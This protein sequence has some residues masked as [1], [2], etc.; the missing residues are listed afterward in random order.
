MTKRKICLIGS[1]S[2][3]KTSLT[4]RFVSDEF[5]DDYLTTM[6]VKIERRDLEVDG[7][8]MSLMIWDIAGRDEFARVRSSYLVGAAGYLFVADGTRKETI[9]EMLEEADDVREKF[10]D[11]P[12]IVL[13]N[14][15]DLTGEWELDDAAVDSLAGRFPVFKTSAL[16]G[17]GVEEAF[18]EISRLMLEPEIG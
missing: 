6:G 8:D 14:K 17:E 12:A 4:R 3:G 15:A 2:V 10:G 11:V 1:F 9:G 16:T 7:V 18:I 5:S 13:L